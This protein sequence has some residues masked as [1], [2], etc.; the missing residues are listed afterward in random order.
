MS[1]KVVPK[2]KIKS[3]VLNKELT[4]L[5]PHDD[6]IYARKNQKSKGEKTKSDGVCCVREAPGM[7]SVKLFMCL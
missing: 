5:A 2:Q 6:S 4:I 1:K 3:S 7:Q